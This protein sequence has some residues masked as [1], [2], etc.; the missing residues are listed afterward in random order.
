MF[1]SRR[2]PALASILLAA[3]MMGEGLPFVERKMFGHTLLGNFEP[4]PVDEE[5]REIRRLLRKDR[6]A[7]KHKANKKRRG[8]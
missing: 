6:K 2:S 3:A 4:A 5:K 1:T 8:F 7:P